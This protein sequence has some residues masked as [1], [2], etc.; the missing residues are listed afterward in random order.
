MMTGWRYDLSTLVFGGCGNDG[1]AIA[2]GMYG[3][4]VEAGCDGHVF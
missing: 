1:G 2:T 4:S 3:G